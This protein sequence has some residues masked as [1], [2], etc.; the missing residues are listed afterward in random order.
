V[1]DNLISSGDDEP[2]SWLAKINGDPIPWLLEPDNPPVRFFA[3]RD[4]LDRPLNDPELIEARSAIMH[5]APIQASLDAQYPAGYWVKPGA[6]Y[7]PKYRSTVWQIIFL[8]QMGADGS[9]P[10]VCRGCE[11]VLSHTQTPNGGFGVSGSGR[12]KPP[13]PSRV[14]HCLNGNLVRALLG[15]GWAGD[16]RLEQAI[17]WQAA[18][19]V[20]IKAVQYYRS[21]TAGPMFACAINGGEPCAW[22]A[23]KAL[24]GLARVDPNQRSSLVAKAIDVGLN[25][26]LSRDPLDADYPSA[27]GRVSSSW[28]KLGFPS[29]YVADILQNL[30]VLTDLGYAQDTRLQSALDW[31]LDQ[32]DD[33]GRWRNQYAYSGK[34]WLDVEAQGQPS[35]WVTL[36]ALRVL[37]AAG[38]QD[39]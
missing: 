15:L 23:I 11:Y 10:R 1:P 18:A 28:F 35:K 8:E 39:S 30:E 22:G 29:G 33:Q 24:R 32:Q 3:L 19:I 7:S 34:M 17:Q 37:R 9:D 5:Y 12:L 6:G 14:L 27:D 31:L 13:P 20:G 16:E 2:M 21:G 36:R 26:L 25:F 38:D 4:L